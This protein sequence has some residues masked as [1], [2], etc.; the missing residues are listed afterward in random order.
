MSNFIKNPQAFTPWHPPRMC[1]KVK[2]RR[3]PS[4]ALA[5]HKPSNYMMKRLFIALFAAAVLALAGTGCH[6]VHGAGEDISNAGQA[7]QNNTP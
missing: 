6:T 3:G 1:G 5:K 2:Q 4:P 7:I